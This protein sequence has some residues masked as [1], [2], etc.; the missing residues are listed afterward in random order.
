M[1]FP[2]VDYKLPKNKNEVGYYFS[3]FSLPSHPARHTQG[4]SIKHAASHM[5]MECPR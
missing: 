2:Q 1:S 3:F 4:V 5:V